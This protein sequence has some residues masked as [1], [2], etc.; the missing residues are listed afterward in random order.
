MSPGFETFKTQKLLMAVGAVCFWLLH[1]FL[2]ELKGDQVKF[3]VLCN[4]RLTN[5]QV[6][7]P[8]IKQP[9]RKLTIYCMMSGRICF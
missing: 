8:K 3:L 5:G 6:K 4:Q 1:Q 2:T 7:S 9:L